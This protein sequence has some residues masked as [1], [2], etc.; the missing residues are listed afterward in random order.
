MPHNL[1]N[2]PDR[3]V[4]FQDHP[5]NLTITLTGRLSIDNIAALWKYVN[6]QLKI[7]PLNK[8]V[9]LKID[10]VDFCDGFGLGLIAGIHRLVARH[11]G[12]LRYCG[13]NDNLRLLINSAVLDDPK[14]RQL[15]LPPRISLI[16][17]LGRDTI[18]LYHELIAG[19]AFIGRLSRVMAWPPASPG[20]IRYRDIWLVCAKVGANALPV[21]C[22][23]GFLM[24]LIIA[25]QSAIPMAQYGAQTL[26]PTIIAIAMV[27]E[28]GPF[29]TAVLLAGRSGSAFAAEI[30]TMKVTEEINALTTFG[31]D[32]V[33]FLVLPRVLAAM[34]MTP[35]LSLFTTLA[36]LIGG[37]VVM[38]SMEYS[39]NLYTE[40]VLQAVDYVDLLQGLFKTLVFALLVAAVSCLQGLRTR[41]GPGAVGDSATRAV[42]AGI[43]LVI[44]ADGLLAVMF[45]NLGI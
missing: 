26:I 11:G 21:I 8:N 23:L 45:Y 31:L 9:V 38:T 43:I 12:N 4:H 44:A 25:F 37:Y 32:P 28:L 27:R 2:Q 6:Q 15:D 35:L 3:Q 22:L 16:S 24:G 20:R 17:Q 19:I 33:K 34:I 39:L 7:F 14:T 36:G 41:S 5:D 30:G 13:G 40:S 29:L 42:V 10:Q 1:D 18:N